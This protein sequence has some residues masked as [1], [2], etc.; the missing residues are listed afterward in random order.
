MCRARQTPAKLSQTKKEP[1]GSHRD[2]FRHSCREEVIGMAKKKK[3]AKKTA[4]KK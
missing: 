2:P 1:K 3:A 4:K